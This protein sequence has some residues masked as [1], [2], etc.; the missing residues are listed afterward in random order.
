MYVSGGEKG[1]LG[2]NTADDVDI[3]SVAVL[4]EREL[5]VLGGEPPLLLE[6]AAEEDAEGP[7]AAPDAD[8]LGALLF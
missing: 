3:G 6:A 5:V 2:L 4:G 8:V 1:A 7:A